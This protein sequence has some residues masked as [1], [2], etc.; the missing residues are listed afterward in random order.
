MIDM[1]PSPKVY[2]RMLQVIINDSPVEE[3]VSWA[4]EEL[5]RWRKIHG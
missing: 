2:M 5:K 3:D 1:K 4:E